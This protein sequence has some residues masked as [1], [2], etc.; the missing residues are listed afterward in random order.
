MYDIN[1]LINSDNEYIKQIGWFLYEHTDQNGGL[2][3]DELDRLIGILLDLDEDLDV[4][5]GVC[6]ECD[7]NL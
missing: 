7:V 6:G 2:N 4:N 1:K 5:Y 3:K